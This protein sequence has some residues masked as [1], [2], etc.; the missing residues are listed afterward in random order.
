[1]TAKIPIKKGSEEDR[2]TVHDLLGEDV[3]LEEGIRIN[4]ES[5][6]SAAFD[7]GAELDKIR[8]TDS[9]ITVPL[10]PDFI[11]DPDKFGEISFDTGF[12]NITLGSSL[13]KIT[14]QGEVDIQEIELCFLDGGEVKYI[15]PITIQDNEGQYSM[16]VMEFP[17]GEIL[18]AAVARDIK[19]VVQ[20]NIEF[21]ESLSIDSITCDVSDLL[22]NTVQDF[23]IG[24]I[25]LDVIDEEMD[26]KIREELEKMEL[27]PELYISFLTM[28][29][30]DVEI[31]DLALIFQNLL[32]VEVAR[33]NAEL[34][35]VEE[36]DSR[37][38]Q[39]VKNL[40]NIWGLLLNPD[41]ANIKIEGNYEI[42]G[43]NVTVNKD[44]KVGLESIELSIPYEF[45]V[46]EDMEI[47]TDPE[48]VD[49]LDED[50]KKL[51]KSNLK[52]VLVIEDLN[53]DFPFSATMEL[54]IGSISENYSVELIEQNLY[55]EENMI[56]RIPIKQR[57]RYETF[58][59]E[60][61]S[62][63]LEIL[64]QKNLYSGIKLIIPKN[65]EGESYKLNADDEFTFNRIYIGLT[66]KINK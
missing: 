37:Q 35:P 49:S 11:F 61:E 21:P 56:K 57:T 54:Y 32:E 12:T 28:S 3:N 1:M 63:D 5:G 39:K 55:V 59:V 24:G 52:A 2:L 16:E 31:R 33:I 14:L 25:E 53:N 10:L 20:V 40:D 44:S 62:K 58:T 30:L 13:V 50:T 8:L 22:D 47:Q 7:L 42:A 60:F 27:K 65:S 26:E 46:T 36:T 66:G 43:E 29:G 64:E 51:L 6:D 38:V 41:V 45:I 18:V 48:E 15:Y 23:D 17:S 4:L 34:V 19:E 9:V